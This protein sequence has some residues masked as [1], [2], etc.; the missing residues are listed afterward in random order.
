MFDKNFQ[1]AK[2]ALENYCAYQERCSYEIHKK[3]DSFELNA[4]QCNQIILEL[5]EGNYF[6]DVRYCS[7]VVSGK[8]RLN[9]WGRLKIRAYLK[10]KRLPEKL[11]S[12]A[13]MELDPDEYLSTI[14]HLTER[15]SKEINEK[16]TYKKQS[17]LIRYLLSKGFEFDLIND[18]V[19]TK[20]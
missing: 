13:L 17:K 7:A 2:V 1:N 16:D 12:S 8:F 18:V 14:A 15:K 9:R 11:I 3:L 4:S 6:S 5:Q 10:Q 19:R 20:L